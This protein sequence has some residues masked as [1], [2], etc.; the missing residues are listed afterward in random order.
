MMLL[1]ASKSETSFRSCN[2]KTYFI[3]KTRFYSTIKEP[4]FYCRT[5]SFI[6]LSYSF[7]R[8]YQMV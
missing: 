8:E 3:D 6:M 4:F 1:L 2:K 5:D 7:G